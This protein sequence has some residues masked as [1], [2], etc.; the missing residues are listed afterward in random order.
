MA[1]LA[2]GPARHRPRQETEV[3]DSRMSTPPSKQ[4]E[5]L[6]S[7]S[8]LDLGRQSRLFCGRKSRAL[9][10]IAGCLLVPA[11]QFTSCR[12]GRRLDNTCRIKASTGLRAQV[13]FLYFYYY[14]GL[15]P[16]A[17]TREQLVYS[18]AGARELIARH[19]DSLLME[20]GHSYRYGSLGSL[21]LYLPDALLTGAPSDATSVRPGNGTA[22]TLALVALFVAFWFIRQPVLGLLTVAFLGSNPFQLYEVYGHENTFCWVITAGL[23]VLAL[24]VPLLPERKPP[25]FY[26]WAV[27]LA[28]GALLATVK[29]IRPEPVAIVVSAAACYLALSKTRW[30]ARLALAGLLVAAY[31]VGSWGWSGYFNWKFDQ[32]CRAVKAAGGRPYDG[33][34]AL[35]HLFWHPIWCGLGDFDKTRGY[36]WDDRSA[37][38]YALPILEEKYGVDVPKAKRTEVLFEAYWDKHGDYYRTPYELPHYEDVIRDKILHDITRDPLWYLGIL[39][40]RAWRVLG[41]TTPPHLSL[42]TAWVSLPVHGILLLPV[43]GLLAVRRCW[44]PFKLL[45]FTLPLSATA[46]LVFSGLG[47]CY[48][49]CY[50]LFVIALLGAW[51]LEAALR[52]RP[53]PASEAR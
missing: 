40:Q 38:D 30:R 48:Y 50:H 53:L 29:Q 49:A 18:A 34:R 16:V 14:L 47:T 36:E 28:T 5:W 20:W 32:A 25:R 10:L 46:L 33:P 22:F 45:C 13:K 3:A 15:Y 27:P 8:F 44:M 43:L 6:L 4:P 39:A 19:G 2:H 52:R 11:W 23:L 51:L 41:Q 37:A 9:L 35:H 12:A 21:F 24:H 42:G 1:P 7:K 31:A 17:T 26:L